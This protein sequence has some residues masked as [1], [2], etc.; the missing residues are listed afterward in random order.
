MEIKINVED[1]YLDGKTDLE[2]GLKAYVKREVLNEINKSI[3]AR[4]EEHITRKVK[5]E[6]EKHLYTMINK[7]I[8]ELILS[9]N[10]IVSGKEIAIVDHIK[11]VFQ[12]TTGWNYPTENIK[13]IAE[14]FGKEMKSRYDL[15]FASHVVSKLQE[16]GM[17]KDNIADLLIEGKK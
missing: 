12:N 1:F 14:A 15:A 11:N 17:L 9:E 7:K 8:G 2:E 16:N 13:K 4:V 5:E 3:Q 6:V 10:I